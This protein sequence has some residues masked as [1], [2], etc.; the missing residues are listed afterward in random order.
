[1]LSAFVTGSVEDLLHE[2]KLRK[3]RFAGDRT[4]FVIV[5]NRAI[6]PLTETGEELL[7]KMI[8]ANEYYYFRNENNRD[9]KRRK[10]RVG[11]HYGV[12]EGGTQNDNDIRSNQL[13]ISFQR[14]CDVDSNNSKTA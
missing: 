11:N 8:S 1:M 9:H 12:D 6:E 5:V 10:K 13:T 4:D 2:I 7:G 3:G 14:S